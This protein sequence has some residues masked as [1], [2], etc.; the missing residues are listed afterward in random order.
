MFKFDFDKPYDPKEVEEKIYKLW[1]NSGYFTPENLPGKRTKNYIVYMPLPNVT[2]TLHMG[3]TLDNTLQDILIRYYRMR[4]L[5]T[6]WFPGTDH[7]GIATQYKVEKDLQK[8]GISRFSL[9]R[10]EFIKRVW[11]W[12]E[13]YGSII[14]EQLK[15]LGVSCDWSRFRFTMDENYSRDVLGAFLHYYKKGWIYRGKRTINWCPRCGTSLSDLELEYK[16][17]ETNLWYIKY[18]LSEAY[19]K[20]LDEKFIVVATTRPETMLG[21]VA[22]AVNPK[23]KRYKKLIGKSVVLPIVNREIPIIADARIDPHFGTG[24]VKITPAH[25]LLD[26]EIALTHKLPSIAVINERGKINENGGKFVGLNVEEARK[27]ILEELKNGGYIE[28][29][30]PYTHNVSVCYRCG[31]NIEPIPSTQWF[32]KMDKLAKY[33][34][35]AVKSKKVKIYPKNFVKI[36]ND[37][38]SNIRDWTISRQLWWGHRIPVW[39]CSCEK[40]KE[41]GKFIVS[42]TPPRKKC[43]KCGEDYKQA[44]DVLDT[45]FSSALWPFA[46]LSRSDKK[47]YYPGDALITGRDILNLWVARMIFSGVEFMG[48]V[49]FKDVFIHGTVL[50]KDGKRMSKSLGTGIDPMDYIEN[51]GADAT[52]F[53]TI[54]Q[55]EGQDIRWDESAVL[56]GKKFNNKIWNAS[57]FVMEQTKDLAFAPSSKLKKIKPQTPS[58]KMILKELLKTKKEVSIYIE[59]FKEAKALKKIYKFFWNSFCDK[60][61]EASKKQLQD[62]KYKEETKKILLFVLIESL[63]MLH[64][65]LPFITEAIYQSLKNNQDEKDLLIIKKW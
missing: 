9:G 54:W 56:A 6:L 46:G 7:A 34:L 37:W 42:L 35:Q 11:E 10:E 36:Y 19:I 28:K 16:K 8:K 22:V 58:D 2:G 40:E 63:K 41:D 47:K 64:P 53:G 52:R 24:A 65:F 59:E 17:E 12:K 55:A 60:Y 3:H 57:R 20:K 48:K 38:L 43:K 13:K 49:P 21:D 27:S 23:D 50:T 61:I 62:E 14:V 39:E 15:R 45:W 18:H 32:L 5:K 51:F 26:F 25:D 4:G 31:R 44:E 1:E 30:E 33:A 29:E